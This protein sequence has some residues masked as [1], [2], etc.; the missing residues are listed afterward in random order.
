MNRLSKHKMAAYVLA[1]P[2]LLIMY[3]LVI[4]GEA[5]GGFFSGLA[6]GYKKAERGR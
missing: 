4:T 6:S 5:I 1:G 3:P 2:V